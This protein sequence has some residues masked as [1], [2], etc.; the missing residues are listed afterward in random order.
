MLQE[1]TKLAVAFMG[2]IQMK[3]DEKANLGF[4]LA[5]S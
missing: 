2:K 3:K 1:I 5:C 4:F